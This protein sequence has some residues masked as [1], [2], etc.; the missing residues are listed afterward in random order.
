M[1]FLLSAQSMSQCWQ[2]ISECD[3]FGDNFPNLGPGASTALSHSPHYC[4]NQ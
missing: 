1:G 4:N 2:T 3:D